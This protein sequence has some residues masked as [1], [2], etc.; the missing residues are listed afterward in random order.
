MDLKNGYKVIYE[1]TTD[2]ERT[3]YASTTGLFEGADEIVKA[4]IGQYKLI[5]EKDGDIY[6]SETGVPAAN[7]YCFEGFRAV[8]KEAEPAESTNDAGEDENGDDGD[9]GDDGEGQVG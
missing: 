6:G 3:F 4:G 8:F 9:D 5:Y 7:D 1:E 2:K